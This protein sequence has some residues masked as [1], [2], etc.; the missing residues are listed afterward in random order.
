MPAQVKC[1]VDSSVWRSHPRLNRRSAFM[2]VLMAFTVASVITL[3]G[4]PLRSHPV[5]RVA[6]ALVGVV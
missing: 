6:F 2:N 5:I 4:D 1:G 3:L